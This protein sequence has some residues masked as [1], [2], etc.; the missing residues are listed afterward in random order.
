MTSLTLADEHD[1][2]KRHIDALESDARHEVDRIRSH[3]AFDG[4]GL[5]GFGACEH[6]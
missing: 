5:Y 3:S 2:A 6:D 4:N 1:S